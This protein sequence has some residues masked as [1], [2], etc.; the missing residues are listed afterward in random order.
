MYPVR[1]ELN[2]FVLPSVRPSIQHLLISVSVLQFQTPTNFEF[3][4]FGVISS[5]A[6]HLF[7]DQSPHRYTIHTPTTFGVQATYN[8]D[9]VG[10]DETFPV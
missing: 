4:Y 10:E 8:T 3:L 7:C 9:E 6:G 2:F 5:D 1:Y